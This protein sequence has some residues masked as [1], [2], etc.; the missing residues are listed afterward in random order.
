MAGEIATIPVE[1]RDIIVGAQD[2]RFSFQLHCG[3]ECGESIRARI[4][5]GIDSIRMRELRRVGSSSII[6]VGDNRYKTRLLNPL[7]EDVDHANE[8]FVIGGASLDD[9]GK[10]AKDL[11]PSIGITIASLPQLGG[12]EGVFRE[13]GA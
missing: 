2:G 3:G 12:S 11:D 8:E 10:S 4:D 13:G 6:R 9:F 7:H 5:L 1:D